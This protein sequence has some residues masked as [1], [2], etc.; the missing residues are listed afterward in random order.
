MQIF[1]HL[2]LS[3]MSVCVVQKQWVVVLVC[4][5]VDICRFVGVYVLYLEVCQCVCVCVSSPQAVDVT[6]LLSGG[7]S[8]VSWSHKEN[9]GCSVAALHSTI[10]LLR[11]GGLNRD[12]LPCSLSFSLF[13]SL[14]IFL[15]HNFIF[16]L[17]LPLHP[18][19]LLS[20]THSYC[21]PNLSSV[22][23]SP[24]AEF[25]SC[26]QQSFKT[27]RKTT[28]LAKANP[29]KDTAREDQSVNTS[30]FS[31]RCVSVFILRFFW[32]LWLDRA[33]VKYASHLRVSTSF[34]EVIIYD[35]FQNMSWLDCEWDCIFCFSDAPCFDNAQIQIIHKHSLKAT[36]F[37]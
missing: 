2:E 17:I 15:P 32:H 18:L 1:S 6:Q 13:C 26:C 24:P 36:V 4:V 3:R 7:A 27:I 23:W 19:V 20:H 16:C 9:N 11:P 35:V 14:S 22:L 28:M 5:T 33:E 8:P 37:E 31:S 29:P 10:S 21:V 34:W 12:P 25:H 30:V